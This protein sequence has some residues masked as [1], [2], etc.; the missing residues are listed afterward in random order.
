MNT[1]KQKYSEADGNG[2][3]RCEECGYTFENGGERYTKAGLPG[4]SCELHK[5]TH[6][7]DWIELPPSNDQE[8]LVKEWFDH[9]RR[10]AVQKDYK[11]LAA[12]SVFCTFEGKRMRC[13]GASR[14]GDVWL[15][16]NHIKDT[17]Y[18]MR[19]DVAGCSNWE[20]KGPK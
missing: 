16:Y 7:D 19:V 4:F 8:K 1:P 13:N 12:R 5:A 6:I 14:F 2:L 18:D 3:G 9:F 10:P 20:I 15:T 17:G 11:W